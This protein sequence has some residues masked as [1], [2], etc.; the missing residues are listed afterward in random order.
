MHSD[1]RCSSHFDFLRVNTAGLYLI[2]V[3]CTKEKLFSLLY[4]MVRQNK[5]PYVLQCIH[6]IIV[7]TRFVLQ[8]FFMTL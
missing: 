1:L 7:Q 2:M 6:T 3:L 8:V 4:Y 5:P